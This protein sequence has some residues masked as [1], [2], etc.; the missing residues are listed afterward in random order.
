M[1]IF[2]ILNRLRSTAS[3]EVPVVEKKPNR[4]VSRYTNNTLNPVK[5]YTAISVAPYAEFRQ[6]LDTKR[7][8]GM[9]NIMFSSSGYGKYTILKNGVV[10][11]TL[12][13]SAASRN[14]PYLF[15]IK[16]TSKDKIVAGFQNLDRISCDH[17]LSY[18]LE[19]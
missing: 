2:P 16:V 13:S 15:K 8:R 5:N 9:K 17:Y 3:A 10:L 1:T 4:T 18:E 6:D 14:T 7:S 11:A 12:F 19:K